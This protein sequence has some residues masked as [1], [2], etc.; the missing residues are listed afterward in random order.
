MTAA[1]PELP[2]SRAVGVAWRRWQPWRWI[3]RYNRAVSSLVAHC[4][5][6]IPP[7]AARGACPRLALGG[8]GQQPAPRH[9][10]GCRHTHTP[11]PACNTS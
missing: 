4:P 11:Q 6:I 1:M 9:P 5:G 10:R 2:E 7:S 8:T 3:L